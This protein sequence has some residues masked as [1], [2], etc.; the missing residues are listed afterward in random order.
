MTSLTARDAKF[1]HVVKTDGS[2]RLLQNIGPFRVILKETKGFLHR[3]QGVWNKTEK[4]SKQLKKLSRDNDLVPEKLGYETICMLMTE[5]I[6]LCKY[7]G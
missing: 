3:R 2:G 4:N 1:N 5:E 7:K 6:E